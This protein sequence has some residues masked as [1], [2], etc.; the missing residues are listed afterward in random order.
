MGSSQT[1]S[2]GHGTTGVARF[3]APL[4]LQALLLALAGPTMQHA[5]ARASDPPT[6]TAGFWLAF[7]IAGFLQAGVLALQQAALAAR[8]RG[9]APGRIAAASAIVA[10]LTALALAGLGGAA[11]AHPAALTWCGVGESLGALTGRVLLTLA[12]VPP[13]V[14]FRALAAARLVSAGRSAPLALA[15]VVRLA[16]LAVFAS[17]ACIVPGR[18]AA[19]VALATVGAVAL[20]CVVVMAAAT[21]A[22]EARAQD[23]GE[24]VPVSWLAVAWPVVASLLAWTAMRP[25]VHAV[26]GRLDHAVEAQAAFGAALPLVMLIG[27]PLWTLFEVTLALPRGTHETGALL[28]HGAACAVAGSAFL[29]L[30]ALTPLGHGLLGML[31]VPRALVAETSAALPVLALL[32]PVL[33]VRAIA[34]ALLL[35]A[36]GADRALAIAPLRLAL[37][38]GAGFACAQLFPAANGAVLGASLVVGGDVLDAAYVVLLLALR[39]DAASS[40]AVPLETGG[41]SLREAA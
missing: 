38:G 37:A 11:M 7:S 8:Q 26:L 40:D 30:G 10:A 13:L 3:H 2:F 27:A 39:R 28:R 34:N 16:A 41:A 22:P 5:L 21:R 12:I 33:V 35:R 6:Q 25:L 19:G 1:A 29:M 23:G 20:E 31:G 15:A 18:E 17:P 32:P 4:V 9:V 36:G 24:G 14:A